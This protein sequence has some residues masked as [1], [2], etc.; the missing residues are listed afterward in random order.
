MTLDCIRVNLASVSLHAIAS[1]NA[2]YMGPELVP[3]V[4]SLVLTELMAT[5]RMDQIIQDLYC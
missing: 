2:A 3:R 4:A 1:S 5:K